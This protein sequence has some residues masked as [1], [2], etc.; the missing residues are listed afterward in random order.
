MLREVRYIGIAI[1]MQLAHEGGP[2]ADWVAVLR[3]ISGM[4]PG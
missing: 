2:L 4:L 1:A 3:L